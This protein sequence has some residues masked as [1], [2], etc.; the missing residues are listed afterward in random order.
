MG[1]KYDSLSELNEAHPKAGSSHSITVHL[2]INF[3]SIQAKHTE[4]LK[5]THAL[6]K[7]GVGKALLRGPKLKLGKKMPDL[8]AK[9]ARTTEV[10]DWSTRVKLKNNM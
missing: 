7:C 4:E 6:S 5:P 2:P 3:S 9:L 1:N 8:Q 10:I